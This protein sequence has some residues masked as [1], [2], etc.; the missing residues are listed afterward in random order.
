MVEAIATACHVTWTT[1]SSTGSDDVVEA[2]VVGPTPF[3]QALPEEL[4]CS[5][6]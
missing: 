2:D 3:R 4:A 6:G 1:G 5:W